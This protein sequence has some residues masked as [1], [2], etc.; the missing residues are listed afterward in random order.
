VRRLRSLPDEEER[1]DTAELWRYLEF[2]DAILRYGLAHEII[3]TDEFKPDLNSA[4][5]KVE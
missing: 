1:V 4:L 5:E 3:T 2:T